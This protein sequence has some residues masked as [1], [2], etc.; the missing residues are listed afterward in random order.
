MIH[1]A[2]SNPK[3]NNER[4]S[5]DLKLQDVFLNYC[6]REKVQV[7]LHF[8]DQ[9]VRHG[10]IIGFDSQTIIL[11]TNGRQRLIY[12]TA[13]SAIDPQDQF[14]YIFNEANRPE[15]NH[16]SAPQIPFRYN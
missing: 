10:Q 8:L 14:D 12:K 6:R 15:E 16:Q 1:N 11:E 5:H 7:A 13:V 4:N 9:S 2:S 3:S